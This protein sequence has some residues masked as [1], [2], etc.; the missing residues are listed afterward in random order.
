V[1][2]VPREKKW[3][4]DVVVVIVC[5]VVGFSTTVTAVSAGKAQTNLFYCHYSHLADM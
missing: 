2:N 4:G 1:L 3:I 5:M